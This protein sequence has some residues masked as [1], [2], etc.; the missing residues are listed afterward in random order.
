MYSVCTVYV[1]VYVQCMYSVC[2]SVC[3]TVYVQCMYSVCTVYVQCMYSVCTV[4]VQCMY[5]CM[6]YSVCT[7]YVQCMYSVCTVYVPVYVQCMYYTFCIYVTCYICN[8]FAHVA[9]DNKFQCNNQRCIDNSKRCN[10]LNDCG[11]GSDEFGCGKQLAIL[12]S[13]H[14]LHRDNSRKS[15]FYCFVFPR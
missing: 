1:P 11:D 8:P 13:M 7:V 14:V 2:T 12:S 15:R 9:C 4:Y 6:F 5:Q 3:S 10:S